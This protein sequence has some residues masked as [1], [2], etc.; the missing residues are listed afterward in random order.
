[1]TERREYAE[2]RLAITRLLIEKGLSN[3]EEIML[4][5]EMAYRRAV[6]YVRPPKDKGSE[7]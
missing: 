7:R 3:S 2:A 1:M 4:L 5:T 6:R